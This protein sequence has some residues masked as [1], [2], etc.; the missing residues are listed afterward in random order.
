[1]E[2]SGFEVDESL[3]MSRTDVPMWQVEN[4][5]RIGADATSLNRSLT[6]PHQL[7]RMDIQRIPAARR[8]YGP[9]SEKRGHDHHRTE[10]PD[11]REY[12]KRPI[13]T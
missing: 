3:I 1:M 11:Q 7:A 10:S 5:P 8:E 9:T 6:Q 4:P 2:D 12:V 13:L